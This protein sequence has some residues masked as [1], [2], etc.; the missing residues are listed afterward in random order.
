MVYDANRL[1]TMIKTARLMPA[2]ALRR[3]ALR[4]PAFPRLIRR[5]TNIST[6]LRADGLDI[7]P[8]YPSDDAR[9]VRVRYLDLLLR[10]DGLS[11]ADAEAVRRL[12]RE[13]WAATIC[14]CCD[15]ARPTVCVFH[16]PSV[17]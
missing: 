7:I 10:I 11:R 5:L 12:R 6:Q 8:L 1:H 4:C 2:E 13:G 15:K 16:P 9:A 14:P 17:N 3:L